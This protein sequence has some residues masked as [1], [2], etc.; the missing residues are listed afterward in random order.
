MNIHD[1]YQK[2]QANE[3]IAMITCYDYAS[4]RLVAE[5]DI[6]CILVGDS[7]AMVM[8]GFPDTLAATVPMM[9]LHASAVRRG[10]GDKF[11]VVDLPFLSYRQSKRASVAAVQAIMQSGA[12]AIKLEGARGNVNLIK[13]LVESGV[14]VMGHLGLTPQSIHQLGG[15][16]VQAKT[17]DS[18]KQLAEDALSLQE[19]GCF[20]VVL[21]C[22]PR[23]IA[24]VISRQ[25]A[26][27]TIG[28]GAGPDT[29]GQVL[30]WHDLLGMT[31]G[32]VPKF[33]KS[34]VKG[35]ELIKNSLNDYAKQI[36]AREFP[37]DRH[38]Y[39]NH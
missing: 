23:E 28:I 18:A 4:A 10:A 19:A 32:Y 15:F 13:H 6:D 16:K 11:I 9:S 39:I 30:V 12:H 7:V 35:E 25:L 31:T 26:I 27:P 14:P 33:V 8:H 36:K 37:D 24:S 17:V 1:F 38:C 29:N 21:E 3:K 5:T 20:A 2:K 34:F 22:V